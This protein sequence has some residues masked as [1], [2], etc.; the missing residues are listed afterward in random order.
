MAV[1]EAA[2][3]GRYG[4]VCTAQREAL[5]VAGRCRPGDLLGLLDGEVH[6]IGSDL[7]EVCRRLIGRMLGGGGAGLSRPRR[8]GGGGGGAPQPP[9]GPGPEPPPALEARLTAHVARTW[10]FV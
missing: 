1:A 10:P 8:D 7:E 3:A 5:T 4:E 9:C 2:G 6:V